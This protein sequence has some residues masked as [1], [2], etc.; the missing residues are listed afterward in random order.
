MNMNV[1]TV[2]STLVLTC[3]TSTAFAVEVSGMLKNQTAYGTGEETLQQQEWLLD[4][5]FNREFYQGDITAITRVRWD[6]DSSLN[7]SQ[8]SS[9]D[10]FSNES[11]AFK[12]GKEG[13][14]ELRELYWQLATDD[15]Y[16]RIG[17]QQVVWGEADGLKLLDKINPQ[18]YREFTLDDFDDSRIPLW[19]INAEI[20][21]GEDSVLQMLLITDTT[22]HELASANSPYAFT[23]PILVPQAPEGVPVE[24]QAAQAPDGGLEDSDVGL[25][26]VSFVS[27][28]DVSLNYLYHYVDTPVVRASLQGNGILVQQE[29][30]RSHLLGGSASTSLGQWIVRTELAY[31]TDQYL[32]SETAFPGVI[33]SDVASYV[34]GLDWQGWSDQ[35]VSLQIFQS[36]ILENASQAILEK[37]DTK[38]SF[39]WESKFLNETLTLEA[40]TLYSINDEDGVNQVSMNYNYEANIDVYLGFDHFYGDS[41]GLFGQFDNSDRVVAGINWGFE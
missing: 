12:T 27:G 13:L 18:S 16:W 3:L 25:R 9:D 37:Q 28:W 35:F 26:L 33:K 14:V 41:Q 8:T 6:S 29:Y 38:M 31:E 40:L 1:N 21:V 22:A 36:H 34:V 24:I 7:S 19:M 30:E 20:N 4:A 5:E 17:K 32:R 39:M 10:S 23:S 2:L 11:S 15:I